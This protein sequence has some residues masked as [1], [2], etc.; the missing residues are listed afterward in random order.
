ME[1]KTLHNHFVYYDNSVAAGGQF[2]WIDVLGP[3]VV[4]VVEE[5]V[6]LP[7]DDTTGLPTGYTCTL[8]NASTVALGTAAGGT[9][10]LTGGGA[11]NDGVNMQCKGE[12]FKLDAAY[13][14]YFGIRWQAVDVDQTDFLAGLC[15]TDTTL[16]GGMTDGVYFQS[17]DETGA[18]T[19]EVEKDSTAS[20]LSI[21]TMTDATWMTFEFF[22]D[23]TSLYA[24][25][26]GVQTSAV[27]VTNLPDDEELTLSIAMLSGEAAANTLTADWVRAFQIRA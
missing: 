6:K 21:A 8:V 18:V 4:K 23:G 12:A 24:W 1:A 25:V 5:F 27:T 3:H 22:W 7:V 15:I 16:L 11:E 2:R 10:V 20:S 17:V 14:T 19:L 9:L 26:D 13:P